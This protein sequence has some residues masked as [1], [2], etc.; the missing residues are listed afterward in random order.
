MPA[1]I[2]PLCSSSTSAGRSG[3]G[4]AAAAAA[5]FVLA[6]YACLV[7]AAVG[8]WG[9]DA[10]LVAL[11]VEEVD[12]LGADKLACRRVAIVVWACGCG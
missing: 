11:L 8:T 10:F 9:E 1:N 5:L 2:S 7:E 6:V 12:A 4:A 3:T